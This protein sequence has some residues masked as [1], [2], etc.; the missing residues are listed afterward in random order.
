MALPAQA[1]SV[2]TPLHD[3]TLASASRLTRVLAL[4]YLGNEQ[5]KCLCDVLVVARAAFGPRA[6]EFFGEGSAVFG[7]DLALLGAEIGFVSDD[8]EGDPFDGLDESLVGGSLVLMGRG[9]G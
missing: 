9:C 4:F 8:G 6:F 7:R 2:N 3:L 5:L 1:M